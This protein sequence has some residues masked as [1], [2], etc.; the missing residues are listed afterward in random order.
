MTDP[1]VLENLELQA[2]IEKLEMSNVKL[3]AELG[4]IAQ[5]VGAGPSMREVLDKI[6]ALKAKL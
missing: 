1:L 6:E 2:K 5:A 4:M 3:I